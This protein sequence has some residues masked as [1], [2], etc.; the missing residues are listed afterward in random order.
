[1]ERLKNC[2][3]SSSA[4][5][6]AAKALY[7]ILNTVVGSVGL[8]RMELPIVEIGARYLNLQKIGICVNLGITINDHAQCLSILNDVAQ[9]E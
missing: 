1:M 3:V 5:E 8:N 7:V 6:V 2:A 4:E 9:D